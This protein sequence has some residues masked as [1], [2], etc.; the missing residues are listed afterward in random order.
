M[1][2]ILADSETFDLRTQFLPTFFLLHKSVKFITQ[3]SR[4]ND[5]TAS[6]HSC[7][8]IQPLKIILT[9][10]NYGSASGTITCIL[11]LYAQQL[12]GSIRI[13]Q[14]NRESQYSRLLDTE[15]VLQT[16][17]VKAQTWRQVVELDLNLMEAEKEVKEVETKTIVEQLDNSHQ[18]Q[19][20]IRVT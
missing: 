12:H 2:L 9:C 11:P 6:E 3:F 14:Q 19:C 17:K 5:S 4:Q 15:Y 7:Q 18:S 13:D 8:P 10:K 16:T 1:I 20:S